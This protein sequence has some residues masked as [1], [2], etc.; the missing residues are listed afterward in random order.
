MKTFLS[1]LLIIAIG[2]HAASQ[3]QEDVI[4]VRSNEVRLDVV[5][6]DKKGRSI[7]DLKLTDFEGLE[8]G[9]PQKMEPVRFV[10]RATTPGIPD[11]TDEKSAE[12]SS[13]ATPEPTRRSTPAVTALV[14]DRLSPEA[15]SLARKA[16][17]AY[18]Q[19]RSEERRVGKEC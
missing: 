13:A 9:V 5:V 7:R 3:Q 17:L 4:R 15:R 14:F 19:Q 18:A 8:D 12:V 6:K 1:L 11:S 16:G 2:L 10:T